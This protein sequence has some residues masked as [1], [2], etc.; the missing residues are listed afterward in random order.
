MKRRLF[1][2]EKEYLKWA[3][4]AEYQSDG[5]AKTPDSEDLRRD[6][7]NDIPVSF[8]C[9][10]LFFFESQF[11]RLGDSHVMLYDHVY[12]TEFTDGYNPN[13]DEDKL[14]DEE[15][16]LRPYFLAMEKLRDYER[17]EETR[18]LTT[19]EQQLKGKQRIKI[20]NLRKKFKSEIELYFKRIAR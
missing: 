19:F 15:L 2:S 13:A 7:V 9:I 18:A 6:L 8:P 17:I 14:E 4:K 16:K 20:N 10:T 1:N 11:D 3:K 5:F 12:L